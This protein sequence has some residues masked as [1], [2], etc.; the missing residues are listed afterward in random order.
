MPSDDATLSAMRANLQDNNYRIS[1]A[2]E[3]IVLSPQFLNRRGR[4]TLQ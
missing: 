4:D 1:S 3:T 2:I